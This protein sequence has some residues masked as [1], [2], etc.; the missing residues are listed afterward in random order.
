MT[1][2]RYTGFFFFLTSID[3][4]GLFKSEVLLIQ[5]L[6]IFLYKSFVTMFSFLFSKYQGVEVLG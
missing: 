1:L 4:P 5:L 3:V 2:Y 6:W